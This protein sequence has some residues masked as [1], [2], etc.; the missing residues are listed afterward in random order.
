MAKDHLPKFRLN[1]DDTQ[2]RRKKKPARHKQPE[3]RGPKRIK[4]IDVDEV[5]IIE[6]EYYE[7]SD[8]TQ[9]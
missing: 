4:L 1:E 2:H 7:E 6:E 5:D 3:I 8:K 9:E